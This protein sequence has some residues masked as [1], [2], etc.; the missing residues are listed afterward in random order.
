MIQTIKDKVVA[1]G[2]IKTQGK[3]A[4]AK[5]DPVLFQDA[6]FILNAILLDPLWIWKAPDAMMDDP[7]WRQNAAI[8]IQKS[9]ALSAHEYIEL[10]EWIKSNPKIIIEA[11]K[12]HPRNWKGVPPELRTLGFASRIIEAAP[13]TIVYMSNLW[14]YTS[15]LNRVLEIDPGCIRHVEVPFDRLLTSEVYRAALSKDPNNIKWIP[16]KWIRSRFDEVIQVVKQFPYIWSILPDSIQSNLGLNILA[17]VAQPAII[18]FCSEKIKSSPKFYVKILETHPHI[19]YKFDG[20]TQSNWAK[21]KKTEKNKITSQSNDTQTI[22]DTGS[23]NAN[24][25]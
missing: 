7:E 14:K 10:P 21:I 23:D 19:L 20:K 22:P 12:G 9:M 25:E 3:F 11:L 24:P 17:A 6:Q 4:T 2:L 18:D 8:A 5:I 16:A 15:L 13:D 1:L